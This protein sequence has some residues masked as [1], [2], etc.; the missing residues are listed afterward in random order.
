VEPGR[1]TQVRFRRR[2]WIL[3]RSEPGHRRGWR[4]LRYHARWLSV[5]I[6]DN[7]TTRPANLITYPID[8][9]SL[10]GQDPA[11]VGFTAGTGNGWESH[12]I[13]SWQFSETKPPAGLQARS[14][15]ATHCGRCGPKPRP[16][17]APPLFLG[18]TAGRA[19]GR[20]D[21]ATRVTYTRTRTLRIRLP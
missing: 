7:S 3:S 21:S 12:E 15:D 14:L 11:Y 19:D 2:R 1:A 13:A 6:A 8:I 10:L 9:P 5:A 17:P 18:A 20:C 16:V 4:A